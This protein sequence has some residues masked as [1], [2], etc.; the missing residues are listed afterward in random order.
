MIQQINEILDIVL[1]RRG[2]RNFSR[3]NN[4]SRTIRRP[5]ASILWTL[6]P[7]VYILS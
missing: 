6:K 7:S 4:T 2:H 5:A 1:F 3:Y